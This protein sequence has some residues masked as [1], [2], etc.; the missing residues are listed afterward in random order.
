MSE[1]DQPISTESLMTENRTFPPSA[2]MVKSAHITAQS[3]ED[4]YRRS[5]EDSD[6]FWLEM[7]GTLDWHKAPTVSRKFTWDTA[8]RNIKHTWF[9]D[10]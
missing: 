8:G 9:E 6:A 2:E 3:Y 1:Q 10:G 7:A 5:V 4:M